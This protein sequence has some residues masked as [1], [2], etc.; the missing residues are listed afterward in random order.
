[1]RARPISGYLYVMA[2][3]DHTFKD[4][5]MG[6]VFKLGRSANPTKRLRQLRAATHWPITLLHTIETN[7]MIRAERLL[8]Q[9][10][11]KDEDAMHISGDWY[12]LDTG[13]LAWLLATQYVELVEVAE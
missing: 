4:F 3:T 8:H 5:T 11:E 1:M 2:A 7:D 10:M 12:V 6:P 13:A 9:D